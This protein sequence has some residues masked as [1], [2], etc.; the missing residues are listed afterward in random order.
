MAPTAT[1]D[2]HGLQLDMWLDIAVTADPSFSHEPRHVMAGMG[3][4]ASQA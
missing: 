4:C 2:K 3:V 1:L